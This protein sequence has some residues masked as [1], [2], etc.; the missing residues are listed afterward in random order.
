MTR[1]LNLSGNSTKAVHKVISDGF[2]SKYSELNIVRMEIAN[3]RTFSGATEIS[4]TE[5]ES[6][7]K[8]A[9]LDEF[10]EENQDKTAAILA[11]RR[12]KRIE[13]KEAAKSKELD[14]SY[15]VKNL[16]IYLYIYTYHYI[17]FFDKI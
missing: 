14:Y 11:K 5:N 4:K 15:Q 3:E 12:K 9:V 1:L 6:V 13:L 16:D 17:Y 8:P 10:D 7:L 2:E